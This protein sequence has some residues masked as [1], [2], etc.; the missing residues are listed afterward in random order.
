[1]VGEGPGG[2]AIIGIINKWKDYTKENRKSGILCCGIDIPALVFASGGI[3]QVWQ[4]V[5]LN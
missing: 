2:N 4:L 1:M 3:V 5:L